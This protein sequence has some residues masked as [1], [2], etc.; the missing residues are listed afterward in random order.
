[1]SGI[2]TYRTTMP[3]KIDDNYHYQKE[4]I[5][6]VKEKRMSEDKVYPGDGSKGDW[7]RILIVLFYLVVIFGGA[8]LGFY[9]F[10]HSFGV[11]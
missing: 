9:L 10:F 11:I 2:Q 3:Q 1:M 8:A 5:C 7:G 4:Y 6:H